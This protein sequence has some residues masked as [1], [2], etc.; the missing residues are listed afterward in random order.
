MDLMFSTKRLIALVLNIFL[1]VAYSHFLSSPV[2]VCLW[3]PSCFF[4]VPFV[5]LC[6]VLLFWFIAHPVSTLLTRPLPVPRLWLR[7]FPGLPCSFLVV[8]IYSVYVVPVFCLWWNRPASSCLFVTPATI[9]VPLPLQHQL[10]N[11]I[12][13][14]STSSHSC[15]LAYRLSA[16]HVLLG[17]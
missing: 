6:H 8:F 13:L 4:H 1:V 16:I 11:W 10:N 15:L 2:P 5:V 7:P 14:D 12:A 9:F 17:V 3:L